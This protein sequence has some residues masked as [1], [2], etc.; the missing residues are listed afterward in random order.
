MCEGARWSKFADLRRDFRTA[1]LVGDRVIFNI[2]NNRYRVI[3][4]VNYRQHGVLARWIGSHAD[5][6][7]LTEKEIK[8]L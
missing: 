6:D 3:A 1:V 5:Q 7:C 2:L 4:I 8:N